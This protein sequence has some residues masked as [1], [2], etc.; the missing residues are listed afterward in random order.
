MLDFTGAP[1]PDAPQWNVPPVTPG[2]CGPVAADFE[3]W[4]I[5]RKLA[6]TAGWSL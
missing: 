1:N 5:L 6:A 3:Q 4:N 2:T